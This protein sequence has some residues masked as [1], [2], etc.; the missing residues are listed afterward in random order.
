MSIFITKSAH[1]PFS[2]QIIKRFAADQ[3]HFKDKVAL[4]LQT[5][6]K[7]CFPTLGPERKSCVSLET[8]DISTAD[9]H[10]LCRRVTKVAATLWE[11]KSEE[12]HPDCKCSLVPSENVI[13]LHPRQCLS[14]FCHTS[15][16]IMPSRKMMMVKPQRE[17]YFFS[18]KFTPESGIATFITRLQ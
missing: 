14:N 1:P 8:N 7:N 12:R 3:R 6:D 15:A 10:Y 4:L 17:A 13:F 9:L 16:V 2:L 5:C 11:L 18:R